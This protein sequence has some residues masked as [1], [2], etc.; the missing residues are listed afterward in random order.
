[1]DSGM[2]V[3]NLLIPTEEELVA[4]YMSQAPSPFPA[5]NVEPHYIKDNQFVQSLACLLVVDM[6]IS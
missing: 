2:V 5:H 4:P 6:F 3:V 1:M